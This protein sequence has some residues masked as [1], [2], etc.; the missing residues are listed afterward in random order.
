MKADICQN[1]SY[2]GF[3]T[4]DSWKLSISARICHISWKLSISA[5]TSCH[6]CWKLSH[7]LEAVTSSG[8]C[9]ISWKRSYHLE[10]VISAGSCHISYKLSHQLQATATSQRRFK[11]TAK[12]E[13]ETNLY[14]TS[15]VRF[16][17]GYR[18]LCTFR[19]RNKF[20]R[21]GRSEKKKQECLLDRITGPGILNFHHNL[22]MDPVSLS[23]PLH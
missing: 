16:L 4:Y 8:S 1:I 23:V 6:I 13:A 22:Q 9:H 17:S 2:R 14:H 21:L 3:K 10:A 12:P 15:I 19:F 18:H 7:Q 11:T 20:F 5:R